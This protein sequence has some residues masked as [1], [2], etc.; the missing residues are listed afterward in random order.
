[1]A[2]AARV[3]EVHKTVGCPICHVDTEWCSRAPSFCVLCN[4]CAAYNVLVS[5]TESFAILDQ[6]VGSEEE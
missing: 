6:G 3:C 2:V 1:M 5:Y 4:Y